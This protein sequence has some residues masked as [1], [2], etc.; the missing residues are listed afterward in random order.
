MR[1]AAI[2]ALAGVAALLG[3]C[4]YDP[5][6]GAYY[7]CCSY[8][9][10]Y[11]RSPPPYYPPPPGYSPGQNGG[12]PPGGQYGSP[13]PGGQYGSPPPGQYGGPPPGQEEG[14]PPGY[15][16]SPPGRPGAAAN[17]GGGGGLMER[18]AAANVTHDGRLTR[19]QAATGMPMV[20]RNFDSI[21]IE[22][23]GYVTLPEIRAFAQERRAAGESASQ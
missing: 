5:Y 13:L 14:P 3:G 17:P 12:P 11:Y 2:V 8:P 15:P 21:D 4:V 6:T 18:F 10:G 23:K 7:P 19:E 16:N 1:S 22:H 9:Y 20:A